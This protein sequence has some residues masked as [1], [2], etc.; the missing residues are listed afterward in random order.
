MMS[1]HAVKVT[2]AS[3]KAKPKSADGRGGPK[4]AIRF[5]PTRLKLLTPVPSDIAIAQA[6]KLKPILQIAEEVGLKPSELELY[7]PYK[8]KVHLDVRDRL[9]RRPEGKAPDGAAPPAPA[10]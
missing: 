10:P 2:R 1:K 9:P 3:P 7:G 8:A 4:K 6:A 5:T